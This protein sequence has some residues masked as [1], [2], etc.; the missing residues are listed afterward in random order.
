MIKIINENI[1][2]SNAKYIV[3]QCNCVTKNAKYLAQDIFNK[4]P[5]SDIYSTRNTNS[6]PGDIIISGNGNEQRFV[7]ALFG[8]YY[9]GPP[10]ISDSKFDGYEIRK[11]YFYEGLKKIINISNVE[12]IAFPYGISCGAAGGDW[13]FYSSL[14]EKFSK[15]IDA[16]VYICK[17]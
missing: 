4:F 8:Q 10:K 13:N 14:L 17:F 3:H 7:I 6:K 1:L 11:I 2:N 5:Y 9:P 16:D 12:S 15:S